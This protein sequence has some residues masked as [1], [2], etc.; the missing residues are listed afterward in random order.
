MPFVRCHPH[1]FHHGPR[2]HPF[3][4]MHPAAGFPAGCGDNN[5]FAG[6]DNNNKATVHESDD[7]VTI[8]M[9]VPGVKAH[10][11]TIEEKDGEVE[12]VAIRMEGPQVVAKTYQ[13]VLFVDP[14]KFNVEQADARLNEGVLMLRIPKKIAV[15]SLDIE[16]VAMHPPSV[17]QETTTTNEFRITKDLPGVKAGQLKI[18]VSNDTLMIKGERKFGDQTVVM[19]GMFDIPRGTE[20]TQAKAYLVDGV[21]TLVAPKVELASTPL[22][23]IYVNEMPFMETLHIDA[24]DDQGENAKDNHEED[25]TM[26][27][28]VGEEK[29]WEHVDDS[30]PAAKN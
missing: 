1:R 5:L 10:Q 20:M 2:F 19:R 12:I 14:Y 6:S 3:L 7:A 24:Q 21:F 30:K 9:D 26:V 22:R 4:M 8:R 29:E 18:K 23:T 17:A 16:A 25:E 15:D 13:D 28:T 11:I 27:E